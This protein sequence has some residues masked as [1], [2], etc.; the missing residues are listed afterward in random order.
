MDSIH[1]DYQRHLPYLW[2]FPEFE[3]QKLRKWATGQGS[4]GHIQEYLG[5][6]GLGPLDVPGGRT[7]GAWGGAARV[8]ASR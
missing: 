3:A 8:P 2:L 7:M 6:F 1:N 4:D 5:S